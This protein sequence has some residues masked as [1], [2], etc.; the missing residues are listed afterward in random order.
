MKIKKGFKAY[1]K[2]LI[3]NN[4]QYEVGKEYKHEGKF[5]ICESGFH[6]CENP[7]DVLNYYNLTECEFTEVE[8][9]GKIDKQKD[10]EDTKVT[11]N[12]IKIGAKL[13][14]SAFI[15]CSI[16]FLFENIGH[17]TILDKTKNIL[18]KFSSGNSS[19]L[20][21]SGYSSQL[22]SSGSFSKLASSGNSSK[23]ASSGNSSQLASS[24][25]FSKL[26]SSGNSSQLASSGYSSQLASSGNSSK[27]ASSGDY[28]QLEINGNNSVGANIGIKGT[29]KG[30]KGNWI[31]LAEYYNTYKPICVKSI[32]IDGEQIKED[33]WYILKNGNFTEL[34]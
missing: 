29:I 34:K 28:S 25:S 12:H 7:L 15:K 26:A 18:K 9:L 13:D 2:G 23:L 24:G 1:D 8:V 4:F 27:L 17:K 21:S 11:T 32:Q 16:D 33:V 20:A 14:L 6:F 10:S 31:T 30:K 19:Q 3:C 5:K 22:A